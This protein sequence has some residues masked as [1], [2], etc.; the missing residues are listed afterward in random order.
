MRSKTAIGEEIYRLRRELGW[1]Q[2][3]L[4]SKVGVSRAAISQFELG[5][6]L[7]SA[8]TQ[9]KLSLILKSDL[10]EIWEGSQASKHIEN[11][12][13]NVP[14]FTIES[15]DYISTL[16]QERDVSSEPLFVLD[17]KLVD[18]PVLK[19]Q[20][21]DYFGGFVIEIKGNNMRPRY[22]HGSRYFMTPVEFNSDDEI[23][24]T[25]GVHF[26]ILENREP[27]TRR[28]VSTTGGV[29]VLQSDDCGDKME[30]DI[31]DLKQRIASGICLMYKLGQGVHM[32][33]EE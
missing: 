9:S 1:T 14:M 5:D 23:R 25:R 19:L 27:F 18:V 2:G 4:A 26:F 6:T 21:V 16:A 33:T 11:N 13:V 28:V 29:I 7:P 20:G 12:Y 10:N 31:K 32:P 8:E 30:F 22:P 3:E 15:Y 17:N 24:F